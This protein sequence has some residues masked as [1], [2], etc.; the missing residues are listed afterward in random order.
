MGI[1][2]INRYHAVGIAQQQN[3]TVVVEQVKSELVKNIFKFT[4]HAKPFVSSS[5]SCLANLTCIGHSSDGTF[6]R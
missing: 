1:D 6:Y 3:S 2:M 5:V 4:I